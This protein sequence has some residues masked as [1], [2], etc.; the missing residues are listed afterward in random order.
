MINLSILIPSVPSRRKTCLQNILD[1]IEQQIEQEKRTDVEVICLY[2]NKKRTI[3]EK[4]NNLIDLAKGKYLV[5][6]DDDDRV[7]DMYIKLVMEAIIQYPQADCIVYDCMFTKNGEQNMLCKYGIELD[8]NY[9]KPEQG[10]I[11][12]GKPAHTMVYRSQIAKSHKY[13]NMQ[14][15]EDI[16]WVK[17]A[18]RDIV[19]QVRIHEI[20]YF[21]DWVPEKSEAK[22]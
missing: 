16:A 11:W 13:P 9:A 19:H 17:L 5:F 14:F 21:Y 10:I 3:G 8:Y 4:R 1:S 6:L 22:N 20:L 15:G 18:C 7:S 12:T 2:D